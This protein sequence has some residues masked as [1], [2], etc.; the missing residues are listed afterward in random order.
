MKAKRFINL[1]AIYAAFAVLLSAGAVAAKEG[2][3]IVHDAEH[4][5]LLE[6]HGETW[7]A[8]DKELDKKLEALREKYGKR[9]NI[10]HILFDDTSTG[11]VGSALANKI[12]GYDTPNMNRMAD[13]GM[14][15]ARMYTE[16]SCT[17]SRNSLQT[18]R[19]PIRTG[20]YKVGFPV[21]AYGI[22]DDEVTIAEVLSQAGYTTGFFGKWHL[23]DIEQSYAT[24]QGYDTRAMTKR[25]FPSPTRVL[26][27]SSTKR[28]RR[29]GLA[30]DTQRG[31]GIKNTPLINNSG[32]MAG[33]TM[34]KAKRVARFASGKTIRSSLIENQRR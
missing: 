30:G 29:P 23:G 5:I 14:T 3:E 26:R 24:N 27:V 8:E 12:R 9:P 16:P 2:G 32:H 11:E 34:W 1:M 17:P 33:S 31:H 6:Q 21:D 19:H 13:E 4:Y 10:V 7:A 20:M 22:G 18:G 25:C 28:V 15:F